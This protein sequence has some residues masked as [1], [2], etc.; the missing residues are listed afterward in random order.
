MMK[1]WK[2]LLQVASYEFR[3]TSSGRNKDWGLRHK[4]KGERQKERLLV[5][6]LDGL[7]LK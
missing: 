4:I 5:S 7:L 6:G 2:I 3:L 1:Y